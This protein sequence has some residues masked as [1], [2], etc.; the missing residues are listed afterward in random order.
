MADHTV[1]MESLPYTVGMD[2]VVLYVFMSVCFILSVVL[3]LRR[4][5]FLFRTRTFFTTRRVYSTVNENQS[6]WPSVLL[7]SIAGSLSLG[8]LFYYCISL[9]YQLPDYYDKPHWILFLVTGAVFVFVY[10]RALIYSI[11]NWVFFKA[12]E[13][14]KWNVGYFFLV[15]AMSYLSSVLA[16]ASVFLQLEMKTV[17]YCMVF[18]CILY[19]ILHLYKLIV[20]FRFKTYGAVLIFLYFCSV[21]LLPI[22]LIGHILNWVFNSY[23]V[24]NLLI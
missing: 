10:L 11:I 24:N 3:Y 16:L 8:I 14:H 17:T 13:R 23:F 7:I 1:A 18:V 15:M 12:D 2:S 9:R 21:E 20:N 5:L 4:H 6:E 19:E 22:L